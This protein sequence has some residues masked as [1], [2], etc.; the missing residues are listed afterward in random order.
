M[1]VHNMQTLG[2]SESTPRTS[3]RLKSLFWPEIRNEVDVDYVSRQGFWVCSIIGFLT[4]FLTLIQALSSAPALPVGTRRIMAAAGIMEGLFYYLCGVGIRQ[5]SVFAAAAA[6]TAYIA[7]SYLLG[8]GGF[9]VLRIIFT[10]LLISNVRATWLSARWR[11]T[12]I[13]P[14]PVPLDMTLLDRLSGALPARVWPFGR[15]LLYVL[16]AIELLLLVFAIAGRA[17]ISE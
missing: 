4:L 9:G 7:S 12:A 16:A 1:T 17:T 2:L 14:P 3:G 13:D 5:R 15:P 10:A 8:A 11:S 6:A